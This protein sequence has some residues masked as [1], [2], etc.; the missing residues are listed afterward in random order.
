MTY[1]HAL[2]LPISASVLADGQGADETLE[3]SG[4]CVTLILTGTFP[5]LCVNPISFAAFLDKSIL[6]LPRPGPRSVTFTSVLLPVS[7]LVTF[8]LVPSGSLFE[9]AVLPF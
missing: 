9:A 3:L 2:N 7:R 6:C 4:G 1:C 5:S 8:T